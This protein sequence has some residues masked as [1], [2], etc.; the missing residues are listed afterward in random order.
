MRGV[1]FDAC[2]R[3]RRYHRLMCYSAQIKADY[4]RFRRQHG[5]TLSI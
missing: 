2:F 3:R 5:A 4:L 1:G